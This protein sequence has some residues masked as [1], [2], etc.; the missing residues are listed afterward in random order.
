MS[1]LNSLLKLLNEENSSWWDSLSKEQQLDYIANHPNSK[2]AVNAKEKTKNT[3][4]KSNKL[5]SYKSKIDSKLDRIISKGQT[6][7]IGQLAYNIYPQIVKELKPEIEKE[8]DIKIK[9]GEMGEYTDEPFSGLRGDDF[10]SQYGQIENA[11]DLIAAIKKEAISI[12][13]VSNNTKKKDNKVDYSDLK[14]A[15]KKANDIN[16]SDKELEALANHERE[17]IRIAVAN[18]PNV[19]KKVL[20]KLAKDKDSEVRSTVASSWRA[21]G[22]ILTKLSKDESPSVLQAVARNPNT[23]TDILNKLAND[24]NE[25]E[26]IR[27]T[28]KRNLSKQKKSN[29]KESKLVS[30]KQF[31]KLN[32]SKV[33]NNRTTKFDG[34]FIYEMLRK[35]GIF[36]IG[37]AEHNLKMNGYNKNQSMT[38]NQINSLLEKSGASWKDIMKVS[39]VKDDMVHSGRWED[40]INY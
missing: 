3:S 30:F 22:D 31:R 21:D 6:K 23:P 17:W 28:A 39:N 35:A 37:N 26:I 32:E 29:M 40:F 13:G 15:E 19:P 27:K 20:S 34:E 2:Y 4:I 36:N 10:E 9:D 18:N 33:V 7:K 5:D 24:K 25:I 12:L 38:W 16:A 1:K 11:D 14:K 8:Y